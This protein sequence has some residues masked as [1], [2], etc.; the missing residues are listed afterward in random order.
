MNLSSA[1][2]NCGAL[3]K[4]NIRIIGVDPEAIRRGEDRLAFKETMQ[5]LGI[6]LPESK[7]AYSIEEAET[8]AGELGYPVIIRPAFTMAAQAAAW[9]IT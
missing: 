1:L 2:A 8:I 9:S 7:T 4:Y 5:E 6:D 3:E